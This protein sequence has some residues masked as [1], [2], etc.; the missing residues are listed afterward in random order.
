MSLL[1][2]FM[3]LVDF[4]VEERRMHLL[5]LRAPALELLS[6]ACRARE[7]VQVHSE[8]L[9]LMFVAWGQRTSTLSVHR[10]TEHRR[11]KVA[12]LCTARAQI[13]RLVLLHLRGN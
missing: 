5:R 11:G 10:I 13:A 8:K 4:R 6:A 9:D 1:V 12:C 3:A 2:L 7:R